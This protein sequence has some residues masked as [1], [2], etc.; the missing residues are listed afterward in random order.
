M[1]ED[2]VQNLQVSCQV[3]LHFHAVADTRLYMA[4]DVLAITMV[5]QNAGIQ[6]F[7]PVTG[8][9]QK[10]V[11]VAVDVGEGIGKRGEQDQGR[12]DAVCFLEPAGYQGRR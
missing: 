1:A 6:I 5:L 12:G 10:D 4:G 9:H 2:I 8:S 7:V 11:I 3:I